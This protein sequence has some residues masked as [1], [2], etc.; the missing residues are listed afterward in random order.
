MKRITFPRNPVNRW[1]VIHSYLSGRERLA[2]FPFEI[3]IGITNRCNLDCVFCPNKASRHPRGEISLELLDRL[4]EQVAPFVDMVD[5]SFDGEPFLHPGWAEC[6]E[7]CHRRDVRAVLQTNCL[8]LEERAAREV[9]RAGLDGIILS[10]DAAT[11][12]A[13]ARLKPSGDYRRAVENAERFLRISRGERERPHTTVQFVRSP[14]NVAEEREFLRRWKRSGA[15]SVRIKPMFNFGGAVGDEFLRR[16]SRPCV[17]LWTSLAIHWDGKIPLCCME[18]EGRQVMG[19]AARHPLRE[20]INNEAF[21]ETR[22][23]HLAGRPDRNPIC[24][25]C[26][27][28]P[29]AWPF[30]LGA[31]FTDDFTRRRLIAFSQRLGLLQ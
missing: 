5:L 25:R 17:L 29:V 20:I 26:D 21:R 3:A 6:V 24:R 27:V 18:I 8:L 10:L 1:K 11:P 13:Y 12:A 23:L 4:I 9:H 30:V 22:R 31:A 28:P 14:E 15:D 2:G 7:I 19:D 16:T